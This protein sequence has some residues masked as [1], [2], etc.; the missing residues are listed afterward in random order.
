MDQHKNAIGRSLG[1]DSERLEKSRVSLAAPQ[2][3]A[4]FESTLAPRSG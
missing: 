4:W 1:Y 2:V 3:G